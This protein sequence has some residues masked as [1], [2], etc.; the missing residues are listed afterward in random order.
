[1]DKGNLAF[2]YS[3]IP[4]QKHEQFLLSLTPKFNYLIGFAGYIFGVY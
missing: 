2:L 1:M 4:Y 3:Y